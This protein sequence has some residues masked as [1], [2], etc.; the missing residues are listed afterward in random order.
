MP[1]FMRHLGVQCNA[2]VNVAQIQQLQEWS[3]APLFTYYTTRQIENTV[4]KDAGA[5]VRDAFKSAVLYGVVPEPTYPYIITKFASKP[6]TP[7][8]TEA[9][10][11]KALT[12]HRIIDGKLSDMLSCLSEGYPFIFGMS[13]YPAFISSTVAKTGIVPAPSLKDKTIG[14]HCMMC[15][16][17]KVINNVQYFIV[18]NSWGINWGDKGYCYIPFSYMSDVNQTNDLWTLRTEQV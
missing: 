13:V 16:G 2:T 3:P 10:K 4:T 14:G 18:L 17:W 8:Y 15:V 1:L 9:F 11:H 6:P 12:Y 7:I 5:M